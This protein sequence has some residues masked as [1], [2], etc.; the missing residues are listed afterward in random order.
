MNKEYLAYFLLILT[1]MFWS[2]N[3]IL[4]KFSALFLVPPF[5]LNF[6]RWLL[7][8]LILI[9]FTIKE[10][11]QNLEFIKKNFKILFILGITSIS[12]FNSIVYYSLNFTQVINAVLMLSAIP[13]LTIAISSVLKIDKIK[14]MQ[15]YG[16]LISIFGVAII[17][18]K[19]D[20]GLILSLNFNKGDLWMILAALS[21]SIYSAFLKK[22]TLPF[23]QF[24]L[25]Q[26]ISTIGL[27][28]LIPQFYFEQSMGY[29]ITIN[30]PF[31]MILSYVVLF[32]AIGAYY[33]W[34]KAVSII[35]PSRSSI[36]VQLMP[37]F[38]AILAIIIFNEKFEIFHFI[39]GAFIVLGIYLSNKK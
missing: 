4:G 38:S 16:L 28:F 29:E 33:S 17:I 3:F 32:A 39:G 26:V 14:I 20:L 22:I 23:S 11:I 8:W 25:I 15:I 13:V 5:S 30:L 2:G 24:S 35:G 37:L 10:I 27:I 21:W 19:A 36:F 1:T 12:S 9:P 31:I 6:F 18:T 34:Q 7:V